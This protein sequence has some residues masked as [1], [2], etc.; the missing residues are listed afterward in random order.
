MEV[1]DILLVLNLRQLP[2]YI[3]PDV[4]LKQCGGSSSF[5]ERREWN[6]PPHGY[7]DLC[8]TLG[9]LQK[10]LSEAYDLCIK[11]TTVSLGNE[12]ASSAIKRF[13]N[14]YLL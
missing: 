4:L 8:F 14:I 7:T 9:I 13:S 10:V 5:K 3:G 12:P 2:R 11:C 6:G 1:T